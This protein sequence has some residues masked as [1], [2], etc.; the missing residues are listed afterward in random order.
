MQRNTSGRRFPLRD[1]NAIDVQGER[2][3]EPARAMLSRSQQSQMQF[4]IASAKLQNIYD[5]CK[6]I[7]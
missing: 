7:I 6:Y 4:S 1:H 2:R 5:I 3:A